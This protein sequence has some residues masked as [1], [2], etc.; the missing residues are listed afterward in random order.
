MKTITIEIP[1][2]KVEEVLKEIEQWVKKN[3]DSNECIK[4]DNYTIEQYI[5]HSIFDSE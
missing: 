2:D 1:D 5:K 4:I 3:C